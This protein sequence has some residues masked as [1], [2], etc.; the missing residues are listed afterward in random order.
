[1]RVFVS[2][3][4][5][6]IGSTVAQ[7]L[8]DAGHSVTIYDNLSNGHLAAIPAAAAFV[9]GDTLDRA[10]L[11]VVLAGAGFDAVLHFAAFIE[12]GES[13]RE[14]GRF[15]SNNV[16]G[17]LTLIEAAVSHGVSQFVFSSTAGVYASKD[18]PLAEDD[19][20]APASVYG[21]TKHMVEQAL[22]WYARIHGLRVA[23]LRYFNAAGAAPG[24]GEA[25]R[26]ETHLVPLVLQVALGQRE[27]ISVFGDDYPTPDGT[28]IRD[29]IHIEDLAS[30][31]VLALGGLVDRPFM[32]YNLGN[33]NGYSVRGVIETARRVTGHPI[34]AGIRPRR[35]GDPAILIASSAAIRR[36]LGWQP[37]H[38]DLHEIVES[39]W[40]WHRT[41]P[42]G[43]GETNGA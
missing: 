23:V 35:P 1:M 16:T 32:R 34:P 2:G 18:D 10:A 9:R 7:Q 28:C 30:A 29:Y 5:G 11:D 19:P 40:Q 25:H 38:P 4:A 12:A 43:Y 13:M 8:L 31:H 20:V 6:Y 41:H 33:G 17:S 15:F 14:P 42:R 24:R 3:G 22:E 37:R 21:A 27:S 39:A 26:P 36:D